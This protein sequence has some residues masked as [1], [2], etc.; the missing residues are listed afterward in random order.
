MDGKPS[1]W[2]S[3]VRY[4]SGGASPPLGRRFEVGEA[5][6]AVVWVDE[7]VAVAG[8]HKRGVKELAGW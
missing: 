8:G 4:P 5:G 1:R 2:S 6:A 7:M 3:A